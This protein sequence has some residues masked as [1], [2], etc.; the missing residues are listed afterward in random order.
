MG[1]E[2][3]E[4]E[5]EK[6]MR[7]GR[8]HALSGSH[9]EDWD[10]EDKVSGWVKCY[11]QVEWDAGQQMT[12]RAGRVEN[13]TAPRPVP[14]EGAQLGTALPSRHT[15]FC[16]QLW[17]EPESELWTKTQPLTG[18]SPQRGWTPNTQLREEF[19]PE[20]RLDMMMRKKNS[21]IK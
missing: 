12:C 21:I 9:C 6:T 13:V 2:G 5:R 1:L 20:E 18:T 15:H 8:N 11:T 3:T 4:G 19:Q 7:W 17:M 14:R 16:E 10:F